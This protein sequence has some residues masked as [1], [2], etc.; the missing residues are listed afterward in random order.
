M[1]QFVVIKYLQRI[2]FQDHGQST[3]NIWNSKC[4]L[5]VGGKK[6][7][8]L[9]SFEESLIWFCILISGYQ[10]EE[11]MLRIFS[12]EV[13]QLCFMSQH[14]CCNDTSLNICFHYFPCTSN[15]PDYKDDDYVSVA[16]Y[17]ETKQQYRVV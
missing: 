2:C 8:I 11:H 10:V 3:H 4:Y 17:D 9:A 14:L 1:K 6:L 5:F 15:I 16:S 7:L 12:S 13:L